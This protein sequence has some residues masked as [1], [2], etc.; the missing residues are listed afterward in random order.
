MSDAASPSLALARDLR[1]AIRRRQDAL[2]PVV[3]AYDFA[4][5][6]RARVGAAAELMLVIERTDREF[7]RVK[8]EAVARFDQAEAGSV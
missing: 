8:A 2:A 1:A 6:A 3:E 5:D 4:T 7:E